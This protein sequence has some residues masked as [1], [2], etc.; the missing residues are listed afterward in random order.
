APGPA[1]DSAAPPVLHGAR[2]VLRAY[3][4][5]GRILGGRLV[6]ASRGRKGALEVDD[7]LRELFADPRVALAHA[8]A[9][10]FGCFL[11]EFR[12]GAPA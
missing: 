7:A 5:R 12:R 8:R 1:G 2:R 3:D 9:V 11:V 6:E 10:E 4:S